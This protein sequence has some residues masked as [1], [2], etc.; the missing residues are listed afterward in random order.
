MSV[1][2][3]TK[4]DNLGIAVSD[5]VEIIDGLVSFS[6]D[7]LVRSMEFDRGKLCVFT[8]S[9]RNLSRFLVEQLESVEKGEGQAL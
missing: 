1:A 5:A 2:Y 9:L 6:E 4:Y 3:K 8:D 7:S